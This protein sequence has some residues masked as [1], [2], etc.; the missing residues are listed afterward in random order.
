MKMLP[1]SGSHLLGWWR[2]CPRGKQLLFQAAETFGSGLRSSFYRFFSLRYR[3][4]L[5]A[6]RV[7]A[8]QDIYHRGKEEALD[9][10]AF[11]YD[12]KELVRCSQIIEKNEPN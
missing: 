3:R 1:K 7:G 8:R 4:D 12:P 6:W 11:L 10:M 5:L 9:Q 2:N